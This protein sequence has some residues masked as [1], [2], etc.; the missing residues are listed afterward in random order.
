M[1]ELDCKFGPGYNGRG[2]VKDKMNDFEGAIEDFTE[3]I[4]LDG[5]NSVYW[6]NRGCCLRNKNHLNEALSDFTQAINHDQKNPIIY[7][8][9]G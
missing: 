8:N 4:N 3:A 9:R 2:L 7:A 1:L 6:H 5:A